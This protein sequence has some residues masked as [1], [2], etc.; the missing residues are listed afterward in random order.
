MDWEAVWLESWC[1]LPYVSA[2]EGPA[3]P[4]G[5]W[6]G[7]GPSVGDLG[8]ADISGDFLGRPLGLLLLFGDGPLKK[9]ED[10]WRRSC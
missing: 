6:T 10:P 1:G 5:D 7:D 9:K 4:F 3:T 2:K 8:E